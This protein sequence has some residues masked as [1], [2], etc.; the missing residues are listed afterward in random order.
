[1]MLEALALALTQPAPEPPAPP[2]VRS[3]AVGDWS[4]EGAI[5]DGSA[6]CGECRPRTERFSISYELHSGYSL[7]RPGRP[8]DVV[9]MV[10]TDPELAERF[11]STVHRRGMMSGARLGTC[12]CTGI[13]YEVPPGGT[14]FRISSA[15]VRRTA[16]RQER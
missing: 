10:I 12:D 14:I 15:R 3:V 16:D 4:P 1:M 8:N 11:V 2:A 5:R 7:R 13:S 6:R 9:W